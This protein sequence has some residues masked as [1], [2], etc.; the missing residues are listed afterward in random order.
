MSRLGNLVA[1]HTT[2][3]RSTEPI[4]L[5]DDGT[6]NDSPSFSKVMKGPHRDAWLQAMS[7]EFS[8]L[9][10]HD[11]GTLV[12]PPEN[13]NI[14]PGMWRLKRE[15]DKFGRITTY[16]ARW[17]A[18]GDKQ[19]QGINFD[20]TYASVGLTDTLRT[21]YALEATDDLAMQSFNIKTAFLNGNMSHNV[22]YVQQVTGLRDPQQPDHV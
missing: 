22:L 13:A 6:D 16:K 8:S 4:L 1:Y 20:S 7:R 9:Q 5:T 2:T 17:V 18:G 11:V 12:K 10:D 3:E 14:L 15:R 21:L 19:I